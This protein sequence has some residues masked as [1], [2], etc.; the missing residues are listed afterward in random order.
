MKQNQQ[1]T[2]AFSKPSS[3]HHEKVMSEEKFYFL[4]R[5]YDGDGREATM[6]IM[7]KD[8]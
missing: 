2:Y 3:G 7:T 6:K 1:Q 8:D 4:N 5:V